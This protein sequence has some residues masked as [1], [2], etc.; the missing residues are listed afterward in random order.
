M[1][2]SS[3]PYHLLSRCLYAMRPRHFNPRKRVEGLECLNIA[4]CIDGSF[5]CTSRLR[6]ATAREAQ[7]LIPEF[8]NNHE[9]QN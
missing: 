6:M 2:V 5:T 7:R 4:L 9:R 3:L 8:G 1:V